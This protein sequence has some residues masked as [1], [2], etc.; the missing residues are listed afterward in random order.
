MCPPDR[1]L[2]RLAV[3][4]ATP[5]KI[6]ELREMLIA[7]AAQLSNDTLLPVR[8]DALSSQPWGCVH[9][10]CAFDVIFSTCF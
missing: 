6:F 5:F 8:S 3:D 7:H 1:R 10:A 4:Q 2:V 9:G